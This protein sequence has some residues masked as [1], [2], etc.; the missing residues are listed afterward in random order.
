MEQS[1]SVAGV[2]DPAPLGAAVS[3]D[4][5]TLHE[6]AD[7]LGVHYM[8][9]YR[10]VRL[11][12]LQAR[13]S[14]GSWRVTVADVDRFRAGGG[15]S[16]VRGG[17]PAPWAERL[18]A[19]LVAGDARG[20]WGV[21]E[22]AL[23]S[24][25]E[26]D[27]VHLE[28][29]TPALVGIGMRWAAGEL[30]VAVEHR[31][32]GIVH[33]LLGRLGPRFVRRGRSKGAVVVGTPPGEV[34]SLPTAIL[35]DLLRLRGWDVSDLGADMPPSS[36]AHLAAT[37]PGLVAVGVSVTVGAH[38][39]GCAATCAAVRA[40]VPTVPIVVGGRGVPGSAQAMAVGADAYAAGAREMAEL[41]EDVIVA[42]PAAV[43]PVEPLAADV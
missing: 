34:H 3:V 21:V 24:G 31:A 41:L 11:G 20:A 39:A 40:S 29:L 10:Y 22:A 37:V 17:R 30:D 19:R 38:L 26:L 35:A 25:A 8:T 5:L 33:R 16:P 42:P 2:P 36:F 18:E 13:K 28:V 12:L 1:R 32:T 43:P 15:T 9:A 14:G 7:L 27:E 6:A 4:D 23:A